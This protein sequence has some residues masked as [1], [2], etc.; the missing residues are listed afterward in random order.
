MSSDSE[1]PGN[2]MP[3]PH[4][5]ARFY[6]SSTNTARRKSSAASSR[7]NSMSSHHSSRSARSAHGGPQS[8]HIAQHLR[9]A[10]LL[11]SRKAR[12]AEKAAHAEKVR[13]RAAMAKAAP[14]VNANSEERALAAQQARERYLAQVAANC[15]EEV[16]RAK[17][18]AEDAR[19]RKA[20]E[21]LRLKG[22]ME[23][24]LAEA[25]RRRVVYQQNLRR[26]KHNIGLASV[27]EK[28]V[29]P[30]IWK[31]RNEEEAARM[32][33][34]AWRKRQRRKVISEFKSLGLTADSAGKINFDD[35]GI[36]LGQ[37]RAITLTAP[38]L[39]L[40][41]LQDNEGIP[42][43]D[44]TI[45]RTFL[46][47]FLILGHPEEVLSHDGVQEQD[48][49]AKARALLQC[50]EHL[51]SY[52]HPLPSAE[53]AS[54]L[55]S[56]SSFQSAFSAWKQHDSSVLISTMLA[57]FA[58]LDAIWQSVKNDANG[59]V[60]NDY[61]EGIEQNK[62]LILVRLKRLLG[63]S[64]AIKAV[65]DAVNQARRA[66]PRK[67][68]VKPLIEARPRSDSN[69]TILSQTQSIHASTIPVSEL[70]AWASHAQELNQATTFLPSNRMMMHELAINKEYK[71]DI[72]PRT[73]LKESIIRAVS[74][75][76]R[77]GLKT[78]LGDL[79]IVAMAQTVRDK[80]SGL[81][82]PGKSLHNLIS[83]ALDPSM[84]ANQVRMGAFSYQQFF[85]FC[86]TILP[87]L[88][89]PVRDTEVKAL[90]EDPSEDPID[91]FA[92]LNYVIDLLSLDHAN[93]TL[94]M[95]APM[96]IEQ[97]ARYENKLF[98]ELYGD[99][100]L[101]KVSVWWTQ[102][103]NAV[104]EDTA[105]RAT[106]NGRPS[107][108]RITPN[109]IYMQGLINI[110]IAVPTLQ[111]DDLPET[112]ELDHDRIVRVRS[113]ILRIV[114]IEAIILTAKN[115]LKRDV[116]SQWKGEAQRMWDLPY[117]DTQA[118]LS[119]LP[120][121]MPPTTRTALSGTIERVLVDARAGQATHPV[122]KVLLQKI[123]VHALTR[124]TAASADERIRA[125][126]TASEALASSGLGEFVSQ[127]GTTVDELKK[128]ADVDRE[129]HGK[130]YDEIAASATA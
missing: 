32:L 47:A 128:I 34:R 5:Q 101:P 53:T 113:D 55:E 122:V 29:M 8:T 64:E 78:G 121:A 1:G 114:I 38:V 105:R 15:H 20:A 61:R 110:S 97:A 51:I 70:P 63:H 37:E 10:S 127:I 80:L 71:I 30:T 65:K 66:K 96:L 60:A 83:E 67:K 59:E 28:K 69:A 43:N 3:P 27:E 14:R 19:E 129:A 2:Y 77:E 100:P 94:Q 82:V 58:E 54:F 76:L 98:T 90:V 24:R 13:L 23:E 93:F 12:L 50:F 117:D 62:M 119:M 109:R 99:R 75:D 26:T 68:K 46:S 87:Q 92:K 112:L 6:R 120:Q 106:D 4:I 81:V 39:S 22:E 52:S 18:V 108:N 57:Q 126:S 7:R 36:L 123:R 89:A 35:F 103:A 118:F 84:I 56:F 91:R 49:V 107:N 86:N 16:K 31:P 116:R 79:W 41:G 21:H 72:K 40:C 42:A 74:S 125:T 44:T 130:W 104:R 102:A 85:S 95:H 73:D 33:Q 17:R 11:E 115:L 9:R 111:A 45:T 48:L 124:L 25:E 88:C